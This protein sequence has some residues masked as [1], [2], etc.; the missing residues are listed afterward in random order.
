LLV[1]AHPEI[2]R[3]IFGWKLV[4]PAIAFL[5]YLLYPFGGDTDGG[6]PLFQYTFAFLD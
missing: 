6:Q 4:Q 3:A 1:R 2:K 5:T